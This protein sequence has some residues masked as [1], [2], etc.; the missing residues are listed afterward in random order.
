MI[1]FLL[2]I[3]FLINIKLLEKKHKQ[4]LNTK[5]QKI[6][7]FYKQLIENENRNRN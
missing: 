7:E 4:E 2:T 3:F 6:N 5:Q 1:I